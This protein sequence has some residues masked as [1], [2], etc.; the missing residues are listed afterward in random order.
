MT[1]CGNGDVPP[2]WFGTYMW[3]E[4]SKRNLA[5]QTEQNAKL[6]A[7][8]AY[9]PQ[10]QQEMGEL[11]R[12]ARDLERKSIGLMRTNPEE[13]AR[14]RAEMKPFTERAYALRKAHDERVY[15]Q[16]QA[17]HKEYAAGIVNPGV[18]V[19]AYIYEVNPMPEGVERLQI[20]GAATTYVDER[21]RE[22]VMTFGRFPSAKDSGGISAKPRVL[23]VTVQGDRTAAESMARVIAGSDLARL[24]KP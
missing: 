15:P 17:I 3:D 18:N 10:E 4:Q 13:A 23:V 8:D 12:Q 24:G 7:A 2:G 19:S 11:S 14:L 22:L 6:K 1:V 16:L 21:K 20:P 9:T 5:R